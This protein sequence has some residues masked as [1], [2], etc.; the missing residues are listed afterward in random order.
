MGV[1]LTQGKADVHEVHTSERRSYKACRRRWDWLF[2]H[3]YYPLQTAKPL[4]FGVAY[5]EAME[6]FY[7]P[8]TW[9]MDRQ[10]I[11]A[12]AVKAFV[13]K[14]EE[15]RK[16]FLEQ[17]GVPYLEEE[18]Q[19]DYDERVRLG[20]GMLKYHQEEISPKWDKG[21]KPLKVEIGFKVPIVNPYT[22]EGLQCHNP[23]C[24]HSPGAPVVYAGRIDAIMEDE[25]GDQ[26]LYDWKTAARLSTDNDVYLDLDDQITSYVWALRSMGVAIRGF[27]YAEQ[28]KGFPEPPKQN[29]TTRLGRK[30][31]VAANQDTD[32]DIYKRTVEEHDALA[33]EAGLY[34]DF[35]NWLKE[36]G[37]VYSERF[38]RDRS[39]YELDQ[40][41]FNIWQEAKEMINPMLPIYPSAGRFGCNFCAFRQPCMGKNL[42]EDYKY[43]LDTLFEQREHYYVRQEASTES[44]GGE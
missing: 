11:G 19:E 6:V 41:A 44:K 25:R 34:D 7:H 37:P 1:V 29:K 31:S 17:T 15:Q 22:G 20:K 13:D 38:Q 16:A 42:G 26:W 40:A 5:H 23:L 43:T 4:E 24:K 21:L 32:Y 39:Q 2:R 27:I 30:F 35:L 12:L 14:C 18:V 28:K 33:Y 10:V 8:D 9:H 36:E 3:A